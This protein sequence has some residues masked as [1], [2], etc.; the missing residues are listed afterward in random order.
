M[1][2]RLVYVFVLVLAAMLAATTAQAG[3]TTDTI[4]IKF[5][6][7]LPEPDGSALAATAVAG[8]PG[9]ETA[10]WNNARGASSSLDN[11]VRDTLGVASQTETTA[12]WAT[13]NTWSSG[14]NNR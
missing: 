7:E 2:K 5:G 12:V 6:A 14:G 4:A 11:L 13:T 8:V 3:V 1:K 10:N 9:V